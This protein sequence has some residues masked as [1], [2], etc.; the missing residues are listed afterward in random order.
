[1]AKKRRK[2]GRRRPLIARK[3]RKALGPELTRDLLELLR[4]VNPYKQHWT[5]SE[6]VTI[7]EH[8]HKNMGA[9]NGQTT[10]AELEAITDTNA[11]DV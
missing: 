2:R 11:E 5:V 3:I 10:T 9:T 7:I 6:V 1:M 8:R 4:E